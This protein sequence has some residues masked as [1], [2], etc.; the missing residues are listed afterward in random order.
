MYFPKVESQ[1][2]WQNALIKATGDFRVD[3]FYDL[4]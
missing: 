2:K 1:Q 4:Q 3:D